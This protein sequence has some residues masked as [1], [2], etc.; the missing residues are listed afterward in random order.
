MPNR[1]SIYLPYFAGKTVE[2]V[3]PPD[4]LENYNQQ[5]LA[6]PDIMERNGWIDHTFTYQFNSHGF[7][8]GEFGLGPTALFLGCSIT[9]GVGLPIESVWSSQVSNGLGLESA[10]LAQG[11]AGADTAFRLCLGWID[12]IK[13]QI[14][15]YLKPP[16]IRWELLDKGQIYCLH[17]KMAQQFNPN[18]SQDIR[19]YIEIYGRDDDNDYFNDQKN[20]RGIESICRDAGV[21]L[22]IYDYY[23]DFR[24][25]DTAEDRARDFLHPGVQAHKGFALQILKDIQNGSR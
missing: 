24:P 5:L 9:F 17:A 20:T 12:Q 23:K 11:G 2:W 6:H 10:N 14:V 4:T 21:R 22:L 15:I 1:D 8:C 3:A 16:R 25:R 18:Y 13:P 19:S 7:R